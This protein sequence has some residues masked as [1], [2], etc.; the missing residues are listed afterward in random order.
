MSTSQAKSGAVLCRFATASDRESILRIDRS[1]CRPALLAEDVCNSLEWP[2]RFVVLAERSSRDA[3]GF[4]IVLRG[5]KNYEIC[6][7]VVERS[8]ERLGI[9]S[10][11]LEFVETA[12][13]T[14]RQRRVLRVAISE[15]STG[16]A[17]FFKAAGYQSRLLRNHI[18]DDH[19]AY[20]F[21]KQV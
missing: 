9:G 14:P 11:L 20:L 8:F 3:V 16:A 10:Q 4:A 19:D 15:Q 18:C 5:K 17:M 2:S 13:Q 6:R 7:L 21:F 1:Q 12:V